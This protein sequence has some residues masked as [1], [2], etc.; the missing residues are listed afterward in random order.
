METFSEYFS[1]ESELFSPDA[2]DFLFDP[3]TLALMILSS[4]AFAFFIVWLEGPPKKE[5]PNPM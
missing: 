2:F 1:S 3:Y 5:M 4:A